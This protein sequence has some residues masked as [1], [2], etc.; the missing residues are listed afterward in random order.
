M[1]VREAE[2]EK[3]P[4]SIA[5]L[6]SGVALEWNT[7]RLGILLLTLG[8][9]SHAG[10]RVPMEANYQDSAAYRWLNKKVLD[11]RLLDDMHSL[12]KWTVITNGPAGLVDARLPSQVPR[13]T[14]SSTE[15][16]LTRENSRDGGQSLRMRT[17]TKLNVPGSKSG[18]GWGNAAII[19][20]VD[21]EDWRNFNRISLWVRPDWEGAYV[22]ALEAIRIHND[23]VE[24]L[25]APFG[26]EGE[27]TVVLRNHEWN[28]VVWEIDNVA[29]DKVTSLE[30]FYE[31]DGNEPEA[32]DTATFDFSRLE[33][34]RVGPDY[35]EGWA[36]WP[37]RISFSHVGYQTGAAKSAI[38]SGLNAREFRLIDQ[39]TGKTV[40]SKPVQTV[41]THIGAFQVMDFSEVRQTGFYVLEAGG[42]TT[43]PFRIDP[44]VWRETIWKALNFFYAERCGMA[45]PGVHGVCHRDWTAVHGEKRIVANGGWHDAGD[46]TQGLQGTA[47][48]TYSLLSLAERLHARGEDRQLYDRLMEEGKWGLD[49]VLKT[50]FGDGFRGSGGVNGRRTNGIIGD[51]DDITTTAT[52]APLS[53]FLAATTEALAARVVKES[54]PRLAAYA[55]K[56]AQADWQQGA[57]GLASAG[58]TASKDRYRVT[59]DSA[60]VVYEVQAQGVLAA[61]E[62]FRSTGDRAYMDKAAEFARV[63]LDSQERKRPNWTAPLTGFFYTSPA[64]DNVLHYCHNSREQ[65]PVL[66][67]AQLCDAFPNH[68]AWMKWYSAVTLFSKYVQTTAQYTEPYGMLTASIYRDDEYP[69]VPETRRESF[70]KQVLN[71]VPLGAGHYLRLFPV[72]MDYRGNNGTVLSRTQALAKAAHL[73]GDLDLEQLSQQQL[74]WAIGRNP[75]SQSTMWGEGYDFPPL[76]TPMSGNIVGGL[77]VGI[78]TRGDADVPYWPVQSTWTYKEIWQNPVARWIYLMRDLAG[79][80]L[81]EGVTDAAV[82]FKEITSGQLTEVKPDGATGHFRVMLPEGR[83]AVRSKGEQLT[84]TFLPGATYSL[85]LR[86]G[87]MLDFQV[88]NESSGGSDVIIKLTARG[89]GR[90]RFL[91]RSENLMV[92]EETKELAL[93]PGSA[94]TLV[95]R[96][97]IAATD[98]AWV[99]VIVP[100]GDFAARKEVTGAAWE[101]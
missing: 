5:L 75:F 23:G 49:W 76:Y 83:Y 78:Q 26:Q 68:A 85:D 50:S 47:E 66:A 24:K 91:L 9:C 29:R 95:W 70:R 56:M 67:L 19:R 62:L 18:R 65:V 53:H 60:N 36:V 22:T 37:G 57:E 72:W 11:S 82:Q 97:K 81:V 1:P 20:H 31:M 84:R 99:V 10:D 35:I 14:Q 6:I 80:A 28:H 54:D 79:P 87:R 13:A 12:D 34:E 73:R 92:D 86:S 32:A 44:D 63:I 4:A 17:P 46:L 52:N 51:S 16:T 98:M 25:P 89:S 42:I 7:M 3:K 45:I 30:I 88:S 15:I 94:G 27:H 38:A 41:K 8:A 33:L 40:L 21:G 59:F 43:R 74:E 55:L 39:A 64:K 77:P 2:G 71:G 90:H 96:A 48:I 61:V 101:H 58:V 100:D 93:Q 69:L